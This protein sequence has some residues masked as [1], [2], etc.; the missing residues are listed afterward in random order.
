MNALR[1]PVGR[2]LTVGLVV[3]TS[4]GALA[5]CGSGDDAARGC[6]ERAIAFL[7]PL[8]G[9]DGQFVRTARNGAELAVRRYNA[10]H[11]DCPVGL[12]GFDA[13]VPMPADP[14]DD[15][16][17]TERAAY[18]EAKA[19][20]DAV[21]ERI[22]SEATGDPQVLGVVGPTFSGDTAV[23]MPGFEAAGLGVVSGSATNPALADEGWDA[24][25]RVVGTD[26]AV[27]P[28]VA[29]FMVDRL[30]VRRVSVIDDAGLYGRGLADLAARDLR[31]ADV[32]IPVRTS[33]DPA[34]VDYR[35]T[36]SATI[37]AGVD[38]V[39]FGGLSTPAARLIRQLREAG[40]EGAFVG[41]DGVYQDE[42]ITAGGAAA[43]GAYGSCPC[44]DATGG[45]PE[46]IA[47]AQE[48]ERT[49]GTPP[50]GFAAEYYDAADVL[51]QTIENGAT[52][53]AAVLD[54]LRSADVTGL[55]K[56]IS[57]EANGNV[58]GGPIYIY[59]V[60][61]G[62]RFVPVATVVDGKLAGG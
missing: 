59:R 36:V 61:A 22:V 46:R 33:V 34:S 26:A 14:A 29:T 54:G 18:A 12:I 48:Y 43:V 27:A 6:G 10:T 51:L 15:A 58:R 60:S 3:L 30:R 16:S 23:L 44:L 62:R 11:P 1:R 45:S 50:G 40:F 39:F 8:T 38:A 31:A 32:A 19:R 42:F 24:F 47:F 49:Y 52:T 28:A 56:R 7:G 25:H 21:A 37:D 5:G 35:G 41:G 53:R 13:T 20:A 17:P 4:V 9:S 57:F 55:T 2:V